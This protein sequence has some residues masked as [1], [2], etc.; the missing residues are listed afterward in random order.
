MANTLS[1][2]DKSINKIFSELFDK[3]VRETNKEKYCGK[4]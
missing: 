3:L 4:T 1:F 2:F